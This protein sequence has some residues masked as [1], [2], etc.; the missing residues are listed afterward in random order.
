M[1]DLER[2]GLPRSLD[3]VR[4]RDIAAAVAVALTV[5][6]YVDIGPHGRIEPGKS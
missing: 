3:D 6:A 4:F 1:V 2:L 5:W